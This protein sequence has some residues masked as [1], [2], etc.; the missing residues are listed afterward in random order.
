[1]E[2][3]KFFAFGSGCVRL[4]KSRRHRHH[5]A[6]IAAAVAAHGGPYIVIFV[7]L[8]LLQITATTSSAMKVVQNSERLTGQRFAMEPQ[9]QTAVV[10]SRVTLPCRV[11]DKEGILQVSHLR[12]SASSFHESPFENHFFFWFFVC[13]PEK[14]LFMMLMIKTMINV[15]PRVRAYTFIHNN[16]TFYFCFFTTLFSGQ[17]TILA[18]GRTEIWV[19]SIDIQWLAAM[20][21]ATTHWTFIRSC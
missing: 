15:L 20:K 2:I 14:M 11:I 13:T 21:R 17:K 4:Q 1:M 10:G 19:V 12:T 3:L 5:P 18:S 16:N 8:L 9:D 6:T 7:F